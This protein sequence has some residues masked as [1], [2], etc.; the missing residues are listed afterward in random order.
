MSGTPFQSVYTLFFLTL[1]FPIQALADP[2]YQQLQVLDP[3]SYLGD[4]NLWLSGRRSCEFQRAPVPSNFCSVPSE[5]ICAD[6]SRRE[7]QLRKLDAEVSQAALE[8]L[9]EKNNSNSLDFN[10]TKF[11]L[12]TSP[13]P[14]ALDLRTIISNDAHPDSYRLGWNFQLAYEEVILR[15]LPA[16]ALAQSFGRAVAG[17]KQFVTAAAELGPCRNEILR[18]LDD[19]IVRKISQSDVFTISGQCGENEAKFNAI[20]DSNGS[21]ITLCPGLLLP[22]LLAAEPQHRFDYIYLVLAHE[23]GH[24]VSR[25]ATSCISR[26]GQCLA[27]KSQGFMIDEKTSDWLAVRAIPYI[28]NANGNPRRAHLARVLTEGGWFLCPKDRQTPSSHAPGRQRIDIFFGHDEK[29]R[30]IMGCSSLYSRV[31]ACAL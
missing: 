25:S 11:G 21:G 8:L 12:D 10:G 26:L 14:T 18:T 2:N 4:F 28:L 30:R 17:M 6:N 31:T 23:L 9:V 16:D 24:L 13:R 15:R 1:A 27:T 29:I 3:A 20:V 7:R 19:A 5:K 22:S